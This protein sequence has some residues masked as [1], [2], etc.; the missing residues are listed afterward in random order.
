M[1]LALWAVRALVGVG[2]ALARALAPR[3]RRGGL[4]RE[5]GVGRVHRLAAPRA[6]AVAVSLRPAGR[7]APRRRRRAVRRSRRPA[8]HAPARPAAARLRAPV[9][10][11]LRGGAAR[12]HARGLRGRRRR[13]ALPRPRPGG[14]HRSRGA[15]G[16]ARLHRR[17]GRAR[18]RRRDGDARRAHAVGLRRARARCAITLII[19]VENRASV[20][21]RRALRLR[22]RGRDALVVPQGRRAHRRRAVVAAAVGPVGTR[23]RP[24]GARALRRT[25]A[26]GTG[27]ACSAPG[28]WRRGCTP[29]ASQRSVASAIA[30]QMQ[31][32]HPRTGAG[33]VDTR[34]ARRLRARGRRPRPDSSLVPSMQQL[35]AQRH[36]PATATRNPRLGPDPAHLAVAAL[37]G[38]RQAEVP[39]DRG[40]GGVVGVDVRGEARD[41][42]VAQ[43]VPRR[44][45]GLGREALALAARG[46]DPRERGG[47]RA[48]VVG[49]RGLDDADRRVRR[50]VAGD[51]VQPALRAVG[52]VARGLPGE[53]RAQLVLVGR[54]AAGEGVQRGSA[55]TGA[56][57]RA[58]SGRSGSSTRRGVVSASARGQGAAAVTPAR[59]RSRRP[60]TGRL[61]RVTLPSTRM[62]C[63]R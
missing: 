43:P 7:G 38:R 37:V 19:D 10:R 33:R 56:S 61:R 29:R 47:A 58:W 17:A 6:L 46:D 13:R 57:S 15:R 60:S 34:E 62:S 51:P 26:S 3:D 2:A 39:G 8:L 63:R 59:G 31:R 41:A 4:A 25:A 23:R 16:R 9:A 21:R 30:S 22:P 11:S 44:A 20:A 18:A 42:V 45:G 40:R 49:D 50:A 48:R 52:R 24:G 27:G 35:A 54:L 53:A 55:R 32:G 12:R 28:S 14:R 1:L 36:A 5:R